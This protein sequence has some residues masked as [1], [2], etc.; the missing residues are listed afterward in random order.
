[1]LAMD[2]SHCSIV[3]LDHSNTRPYR[4]Q[5]YDDDEEDNDNSPEYISILEKVFGQG[6]YH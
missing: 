4:I 2:P 1:M 6:I 5:L 3:V